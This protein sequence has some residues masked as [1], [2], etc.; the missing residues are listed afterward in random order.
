MARPLWSPTVTALAMVSLAAAPGL[1]QRRVVQSVVSDS[2]PRMS[3]HVASE[4][5]FLG[6]AV[7][8]V[9]TVGEAEQFIF[10]DTAGGAIRR[11]VIVH[12]EHFLPSNSRTFDYPRLEMATL[13]RHEYLRQTWALRRFAGFAEPAVRRLLVAAGLRADTAWVMD[14]HVR[15]VDPERKREVILFYLESSTLHRGLRFGGAPDPP[16]PPTPPDSILRAVRD[17]AGRAFAVVD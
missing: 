10:A 2:H 14:R 15:A 4:F 12:F 7:F 6:R 11:A 3:V 13:G 16:P 9:G 8:P 17:R 5:A 1:S